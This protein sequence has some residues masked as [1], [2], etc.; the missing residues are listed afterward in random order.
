MLA[1]LTVLL[2]YK[3][4]SQTRSIPEKVHE[5]VPPP[6]GTNYLIISLANNYKLRRVGQNLLGFRYLKRKK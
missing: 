4:T 3:Q 6:A 1:I 2:I 5:K